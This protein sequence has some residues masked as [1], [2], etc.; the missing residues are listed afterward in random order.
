MR[1]CVL[2]DISLSLF[3]SLS[4]SLCLSLSLSLSLTLSLSISLPNSFSPSSSTEPPCC[5]HL[6]H[7]FHTPLEL[8]LP[9]LKDSTPG[10]Q[11]LSLFPRP[12][13]LHEGRILYTSCDGGGASIL[14]SHWTAVSR[15]EVQNQAGSSDRQWYRPSSAPHRHH[16]HQR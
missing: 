15:E 5:R 13:L 2:A 4:F 1:L 8:H 12:P 7:K 10:V 6:L 9:Q 3:L 16:R 11:P 14:L